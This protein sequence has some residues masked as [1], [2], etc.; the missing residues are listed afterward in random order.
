MVNCLLV[1]AVSGNPEKAADAV[2]A[3]AKAIWK[4]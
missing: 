1:V 2:R 4:G 3:T